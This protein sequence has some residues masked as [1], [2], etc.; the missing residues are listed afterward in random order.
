MIKINENSENKA[1]FGC[2]ETI[3]KIFYKIMDIN[4]IN[5]GDFL[6]YTKK[7]LTYIYTQKSLLWSFTI[8]SIIFI[9]FFVFIKEFSLFFVVFFIIIALFLLHIVITTFVFLK[10]KSKE[11]NYSKRYHGKQKKIIL[12]NLT[13]LDLILDN[14]SLGKI[15]GETKISKYLSK[16]NK[17]K[18]QIENYSNAISSNYQYLEKQYKII[19]TILSTII[20]IATALY[21]YFSKTTYS[22][23]KIQ[24]TFDFLKIFLVIIA[25]LCVI[26]SHV[27]NLIIAIEKMKRIE[28]SNQS[29]FGLKDQREKLPNDISKLRKKIN[30]KIHSDLESSKQQ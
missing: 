21:E 6:P 30:L 29:E 22:D 24:A 3:F 26:L 13:Q 8:L 15:I 2:L 5:V 28:N 20:P 27:G 23:I 10:F 12:K 17:I 7:Y 11:F 19:S 18:K 16:R 14:N 25:I 4:L 9:I 1:Y